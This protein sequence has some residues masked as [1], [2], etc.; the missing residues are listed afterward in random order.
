[1]L[2]KVDCAGDKEHHASKVADGQ[3]LQ[4][5]ERK[6]RLKKE[7]GQQGVQTTGIDES[8]SFSSFVCMHSEARL[9]TN[10]SF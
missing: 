1:V 3:H 5:K 10:S 8:S 9:I 2:F 6:R 7:P 4:K